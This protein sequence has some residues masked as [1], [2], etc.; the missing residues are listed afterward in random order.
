MRRLSDIVFNQ[1]PLTLPPTASVKEACRHMRDY[2]VGAILVVDEAGSLLGIF[3]GRDAVGKV[4]AEGKNPTETKLDDV[5]TPTPKTM[6]PETTA[7]EALRLM[8]DGGF[9]HIPIVDEGAVV[10][11]VSRGDFQAREA[12]RLEEER[13]IWEHLR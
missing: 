7:I 8:W 5:M 2:R 3:T 1:E 11:V 12:E 13:E 10:G 4:L 9:R 6:P